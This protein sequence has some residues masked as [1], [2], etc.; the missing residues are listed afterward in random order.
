GNLLKANGF[1]EVETPNGSK[2]FG[3]WIRHY[4][5]MF[6][7]I[8]MNAGPIATPGTL[9]DP[10]F[11]VSYD[12]PSLAEM[13]GEERFYNVVTI[14]E[15]RGQ[16]MPDGR[17]GEAAGHSEAARPAL[18]RH[19]RASGAGKTVLVLEERPEIA[20]RLKQ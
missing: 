5:M 9:V 19:G 18:F 2:L 12:D 15:L 6:Y 3:R 4:G 11:V 16:G 13:R 1:S 17:R 8:I 10:V 20:L 14:F 7:C